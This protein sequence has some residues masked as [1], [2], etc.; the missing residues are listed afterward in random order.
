MFFLSV[1]FISSLYCDIYAQKNEILLD[2]SIKRVYNSRFKEIKIEKG[3]DLIT[4][5]AFFPD[6]ILMSYSNKI[7]ISFQKN[8]ETDWLKTTKSPLYN[9]ESFCINEFEKEN[10]NRKKVVKKE[11]LVSFINADSLITPAFVK[12]T[13][14]VLN[15]YLGQLAKH[16]IESDK[17]ILKTQQEALK[18]DANWQNRIQ[19]IKD[20]VNRENAKKTSE[21]NNEISR[22][23]KHIND[24]IKVE[25]LKLQ[26]SAKAKEALD[27]MIQSVLF[28]KTDF[29]LKNANVDDIANIIRSFYIIDYVYKN[30]KDLGVDDKQIK[31]IEDKRKTLN[32][33]RQA[34][35]ALLESKAFTSGEIN[36][37]S[38][39]TEE[40][41]SIEYFKY[42]NFT[43]LQQSEIKSE[44]VR[45]EQ[46][47]NIKQ[48]FNLILT[49]LDGKDNEG[50]INNF[51][52]VV[53]KGRLYDEKKANMNRIVTLFKQKYSNWNQF[54]GIKD[55]INKVE[56]QI[57]ANPNGSFGQYTL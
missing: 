10:S 49:T 31:E 51:D 30:I 32:H 33:V 14:L 7:I 4:V 26:S 36:R 15:D 55:R 25:M 23:R 29:S 54:E 48:Q 21:Q 45:V 34:I 38:I 2:N 19:L 11:E 35:D 42:W 39:D 18:Q 43:P 1:V 52:K 57:N 50:R 27:L 12:I 22:L 56:N 17:V 5:S 47:K 13:Q 9:F 8:Y 46:Y 3:A 24:S 44:R 28:Q 53:E 16:Q 6:S 20:S 41:L 37:I 40:L